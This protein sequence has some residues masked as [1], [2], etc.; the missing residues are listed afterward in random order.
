MHPV[1]NFMAFQV[2][3]FACVL[4]AANGMPWLGPVVAILV[5]GL[6][7][8][9]VAQPAGEGRLILFAMLM[10]VLLDS[11]LVSLGL[12][13]YISG[14]WV[15]GFAPLWIVTMW[16][17]LATTLNVSMR[18][19]RGRYALAVLM[20]SVA[21]PLSYLAGAR[22]GAVL[23]PDMRPA[24]LALAVIW[25]VAMPVLMWLAARFDGTRTRIRQ[26]TLRN[27]VASP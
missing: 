11:A 16:A 22:L 5:V 23:I 26:A 27:I 12:L 10:G 3:W 6:H 7:L 18:W 17:L 20:G 4:G 15:P 14:N 2:G 19:L 9:A 21:G 25:G 8:A 13:E 24:L 1:A